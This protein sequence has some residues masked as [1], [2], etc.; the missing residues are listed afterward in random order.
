MGAIN[1]LSNA[2][3]RDDT[4]GMIAFLDGQDR[5]KEGP[6]GVV[7][8]CMGGAFVTDAAAYFP[9]RVAAVASL[10]GTRLITDKPDSPHLV[11]KQAKA[12]FYYAFAEVDRNASPETIRS[13]EK[14]LADA[15][16]KHRVETFPGTHHGFCFPERDVYVHEA[17]ETTWERMFDLW[18]G[19]LR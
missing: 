10:Y 17:A 9:R 1:H 2:R 13:F 19:R 14:V 18:D 11:V 12:E 5:V 3:I 8:Y 6:L 4:A 15:N 7:G 16:V